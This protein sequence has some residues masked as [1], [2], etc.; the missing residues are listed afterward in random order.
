MSAQLAFEHAVSTA[1]RS[2]TTSPPRARV[3]VSCP[4]EGS[5]QEPARRWW[6]LSFCRSPGSSGA[7][8]WRSDRDTCCPV[9][10]LTPSNPQSERLFS[11]PNQ[12][13]PTTPPLLPRARPLGVTRVGFLYPASSCL[14]N[15]YPASLPD[16][17]PHRAVP[18][19]ALPEVG[20]SQP[21]RIEPRPQ[22][23]CDPAPAASWHLHTS[24]AHVGLP[25]SCASPAGTTLSREGERERERNRR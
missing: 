16:S 1:C 25:A 6:C 19:D 12:A 23:A 3:R 2:N 9:S 22:P 13:S 14:K 21:L 20:G 4:G 7:A 17:C 11:A 15:S 5:G 8:V 10:S 18:P 24:R